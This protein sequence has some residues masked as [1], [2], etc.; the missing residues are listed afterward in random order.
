MTRLFGTDGVRGKANVDLTPDLALTLG[1][2][3]GIVFGRPGRIF[4]GRD[5]RVSGPMLEGALTAGLCSAGLH[6]AVAGI[7]PTPAVSFLTLDESATAG[8]VVS[9]SHNPVD[10]NGIKFFSAEGSKIGADVETAIEA[11]METAP[12]GLPA[13]TEVGRAEVIADAAGRYVDH[14]VGTL[15]TTLKGLRVVVDCAYG[16]AWDVGPRAF[17]AAGADVIA[18]N[19]APDGTRINVGCGSTS[20]E[21][22]I[23]SVLD[24]RADL[25]VAFDGDA[26]RVL[27]VDERGSVIDGDAILA[28]AAVQ[29]AEAGE[30]AHNVV[31][32]TVM[33]NLGLQHALADRG[34]EVVTVPVGD[35]FVSEGMLE[36]GASLGGEQSGH[37]IFG[38]HART[39]DGILAGLQLA[40]WVVGQAASECVHVFEPYPQVLINVPVASKDALESAAALWE[41]VGK[42]Q[43]RFGRDGR[44]L[45]RASGTEALVRVMVE[46]RDEATARSSAESLA[47]VVRDQLGVAPAARVRG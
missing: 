21:P 7:I 30:L 16:A 41:Q 8:G 17:R 37:I 45:V 5:T 10:D 33:A 1:R 11:A 44:V 40:S 9:A 23:R 2:A 13:G 28:L 6:V 29:L 20:L 42:L 38:A 36:A 22:L 24:E 32:S 14:L 25:G 34:I 39:G 35:R 46:A 4:L 26:D 15:Q 3:A 19:A 27:A 31:V 18:I 12:D 43:D 47:A